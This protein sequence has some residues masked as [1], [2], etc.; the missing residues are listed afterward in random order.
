MRRANAACAQSDWAEAERLCRA[1]LAARADDLEALNLLGIIGAQTRRLDLAVDMFGRA[2]AA[3]PEHAVVHNNHANALRT[4]GR[5]AEA[6]GAC[7]R[8]LSL[9]PQYPEAHNSRGGVLHQLGR[10]EDAAASF[11]RA[12]AI[13]ADYPEALYNRA[14]ALQ[15]LDRNEDAALDLE[16]AVA[17]NPQFAEAHYNLGNALR[18]LNRPAEAARSFELALKAK[19]DFAQAHNNLGSVL[20]GLGLK[21]EAMLHFDRALQIAP[22]LAAAYFN[23]GRIRE[24][25]GRVDEAAGDYERAL[26]IDRSLDW[27]PGAW[28]YLQLR[29]CEWQGLEASTASI[30]SAVAEGRRAAQ[31]HTV[32]FVSDDPALQRRAAAISAEESSGFRR[33]LGPIGR[34]A[35]HDKIRIGYFSGDYHNHATAQ[36]AAG[37]FEEHDR[38]RFEV[39]G[40]SFGPDKSDPMRRRLAAG[41]DRFVDVRTRSDREIAQLSREMEIDIAIDLKGFTRDSRT[42]ILARRA[43]PVQINYLGYPGTMG[44]AFMDY[45]VADRIVIPPDTREHYAERIIF[46]P[47][48]YQVNDRRRQIAPLNASREELGLPAAGFVFCCFNSNVKITQELFESWLRILLRAP[49]SVLWLLGDNA[50]AQSNLR[51]RTAVQGIDPGRLIFAP[52]LPPAEH[53]ARYRAADLFLDTFP[54]NAHTTASDALWAGVPVLTRMGR[55]FGSR[56]AASLLHAIGLEALVTGTE[57]EYEAL[58]VRLAAHPEEIAS[59]KRRMAESRESVPLFDTPRFTRQIEDAYSMVYERCQRG[60]EPQDL[61]VA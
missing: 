17:I 10:F 55:S 4:L 60:L 2:A 33:P 49:G 37:L 20:E 36:L 43:A 14:L 12:L 42:G 9:N 34:Y 7:D 40:F 39:V 38:A 28:L 21:A 29:R 13:K 6:L 16:R 45:L 54:C 25:L 57:Q 51:D 56:V 32:V 52:Y 27:L 11:E 47:D 46:L 50:T 53:L 31:A 30:L 61:R 5:L 58:A 59:L 15:D 24:D 8:A 1:I 26:G 48:S 3:H 23:R 41:F 44:S 35:R 19:P 18:D 22:T